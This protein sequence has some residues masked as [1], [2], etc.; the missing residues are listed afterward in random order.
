M[1]YSRTVGRM[2]QKESGGMPGAVKRIRMITVEVPLS[3]DGAASG[4]TCGCERGPRSAS[5]LC[6]MDTLIPERIHAKSIR[7]PLCTF[8]GDRA[9]AVLSGMK[10]RRPGV[11]KETGG[12]IERMSRPVSG[13]RME[14]SGLRRR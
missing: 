4:R 14:Y 3:S 7:T 5:I 9:M 13:S 10:V 6:A 12:S 11:S 8:G 2:L 1:S